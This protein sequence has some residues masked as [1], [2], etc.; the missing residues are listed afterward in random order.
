MGGL[1]GVTPVYAAA[2]GFFVFASVGLPGLSGFVG[3]FLTLVGAFDFSPWVAGVAAFVMILAAAYLLWMFQRLFTGEVSDFLRGLGHHLTDLRPIEIL[4]LAP[5]AAV[6]VALG[7]FP[8]LVL[9]LIGDPVGSVLGEVAAAAP[10]HLA[11]W[12]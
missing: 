11:L 7:V 10:I 6:V 3:E 4:T 2:F 5:L 1:A 12:R 9:D 8:G